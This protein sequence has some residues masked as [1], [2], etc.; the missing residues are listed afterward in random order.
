MAYFVD[1]I[2]HG[3]ELTVPSM[4]DALQGLKV[5]T[6]VIESAERGEEVELD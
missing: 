3:Q 6:A 1:R 2:L 5:V 4:A